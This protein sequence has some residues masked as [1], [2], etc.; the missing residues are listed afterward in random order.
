MHKVG[1]C[2]VLCSDRRNSLRA[3]AAW[4]FS[5]FGRVGP[6]HVDGYAFAAAEVNIPSP[7]P[8]RRPCSTGRRVPGTARQWRTAARSRNATTRPPRSAST[9]WA[10]AFV[11]PRVPQYRRRTGPASRA[12]ASATGTGRRARSGT[13]PGPATRTTLSVGP[14]RPV[15]RAAPGSSTWART[16]GRA[17]HCRRWS[18]PAGTRSAP[19]SATFSRAC[20]VWFCNGATRTS[21][22]SLIPR[23]YSRPP[24]GRPPAVYEIRAGRTYGLITNINTSVTD[25]L[26]TNVFID[27]TEYC[28]T[29]VYTKERFS[30]LTPFGAKKI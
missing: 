6:Q 19:A 22:P 25:F 11:G 26:I 16:A 13:G 7:A 30:S 3:S 20:P 10:P 9:R 29:D 17:P 2:V 15:P 1:A 8:G 23:I 18:W 24:R 5:S 27:L 21:E 28:L 14:C 4:A 12:W